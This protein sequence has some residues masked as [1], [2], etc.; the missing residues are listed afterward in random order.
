MAESTNT[1]TY[2]GYNAGTSVDVGLGTVP[3]SDWPEVSQSELDKEPIDRLV[4]GSEL[5]SRVREYV[6]NRLRF[7]ERKMALFTPRW[8]WNEA[9]V[10]AFVQLPDYEQRLKEMN[11]RREPPAAVS[12]IVPYSYA[13]IMTISTYHLHTFAGHRPMFQVGANKKETVNSA[14]NMEIVL[15]YNADHTRLISKLWQFLLDSQIYGVGIMRCS[16]KNQRAMRTIW[17]KQGGFL[18]IGGTQVKS[19]ENRLVYSGNDICNIDPFMFFPDPRVPMASVNKEGEFV[20]W[21]EFMGRHKAKG[22]EADK[23]WKWVNAA[24]TMPSRA[25]IGQS[26]SQSSRDLVSGGIAIPGRDSIDSIMMQNYVQA[27]QGSIEIIPAELGLGE[28][29]RPQ[30]WLFTILNGRQIVQAEPLELDHGM[31]PVVVSEPSSIGYGFGQAGLA[32]YLGGMQDTMSWLVN[33]HIH[34]VRTALNNSLVVDPSRIEMQD[35]KNPAP[36]KII[37][38]KPAGYGQD[39]QTMLQQLQIMDVTRAHMEDLQIFTRMADALSGVNDNVRGLQDSGGR[40]T[41]TEV[42]T[43]GEA[44]AS[45][46]AAQSRVISAQAIVDLTEQMTVNIQQFLED[47]LY[48]MIVGQDGANDPIHIQPEMLVG[49]FHYPVNDGTLPIDRVAMLDVWKEIFLGLSQ[50]PQLSQMYDRS[51]IFEFIAELGGAKNLSNFKIQAMP[52]EQIANQVQA[53][54][55]MPI[56]KPRPG[57]G[58]PG[59]EPNPGQRLQGMPGQGRGNS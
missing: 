31:H 2:P 59:V 33:S 43:S 38:V 14:Q 7:S 36:G 13:T 15:Q 35:V 29:T 21:R 25:M 55:M 17:K 10:Q 46:L 34:N 44:A 24:G 4:P 8:R 40:K 53:G 41:A 1:E 32:D 50:D 22:L 27:D 28:S 16:W 49:D 37:R 5:H 52:D 45:R 54:N 51:K 19:R 57:G 26:Y 48:L 3:K 20:F 12:I 11:E 42:R 30:K 18:G 6:M 23:V 56:A 58:T 39:P 9:R 47:E